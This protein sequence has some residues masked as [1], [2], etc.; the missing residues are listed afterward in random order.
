MEQLNEEADPVLIF[1]VS[2]IKLSLQQNQM[3]RKQ[4][5]EMVKAWYG[6]KV[7]FLLDEET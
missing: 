2:G 6:D 5:V 7:I 1:V 3:S 4:A